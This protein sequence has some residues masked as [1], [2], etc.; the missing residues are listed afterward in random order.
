MVAL[1]VTH[2]TLGT[3]LMC[4]LQLSSVQQGPCQGQPSLFPLQKSEG[5]QRRPSAVCHEPSAGLS[6]LTRSHNGLQDGC[7]TCCLDCWFILL[8]LHE[9]LGMLLV[10]GRIAFIN[11]QGGSEGF[12]GG[13]IVTSLCRG[14]CLLHQLLCRT[15]RHGMV[16]KEMDGSLAEE[17]SQIKIDPK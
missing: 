10:Q 2:Q 15:G 9:A 6:H 11:G 3:G 16:C 4:A 17:C 12:G 14:C 1:H 5:G 7:S 8:Q 13:R